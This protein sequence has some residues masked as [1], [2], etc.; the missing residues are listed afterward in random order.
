MVEYLI[1]FFVLIL[2]AI[3]IYRIMFSCDSPQAENF[4]SNDQVSV[5]IFLSSSCHHCT[6]YKQNKHES[7]KQF[8]ESKGYKYVL[9]PEDDSSMFTKYDVMYIPTCVIVKGN[10]H[11]KLQGEITE[12]NIEKA[13]KSL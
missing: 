12:N 11:T 5:L 2:I 9:V 13:I 7:I 1:L 4:S 3:F 10:K 6:T 8:V